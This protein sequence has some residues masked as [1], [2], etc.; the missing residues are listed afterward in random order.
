MKKKLA[1]SAQYFWFMYSLLPGQTS[2]LQC[3]HRT[4]LRS[5]L[6]RLPCSFS[7]YVEL[8]RFSA[9]C[10]C[11]FW[12]ALAPSLTH[13]TFE[14]KRIKNCSFP[15]YLFADKS[16]RFVKA[17]EFCFFLS[18]SAL[19]LLSEPFAVKE[20][21]FDQQVLKNSIESMAPHLS[22]EWDWEKKK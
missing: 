12:C 19:L 1:K 13:C 15:N 9:K 17:I 2:S 20:Y 8:C 10:A 6:I 3:I 7:V 22:T 11:V 14:S 21:N 16:V 4:I 5:E 18:H